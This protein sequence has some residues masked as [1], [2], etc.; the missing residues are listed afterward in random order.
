[1]RVRPALRLVLRASE[2]IGKEI[3]AKNKRRWDR[4]RVREKKKKKKEKRGRALVRR[5]TKILNA[6][7]FTWSLSSSTTYVLRY[8]LCL[9]RIGP[10]VGS[11][12]YNGFCAFM[13][14]VHVLYDT[15]V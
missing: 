13:I 12:V 10:V 11:V 4:D 3:K 14:N 9:H 7:A 2:H 8:T 15:H 1:M 5:Y 6:I